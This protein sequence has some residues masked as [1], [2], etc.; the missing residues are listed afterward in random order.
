MGFQRFTGKNTPLKPTVSSR[1]SVTYGVAKELARI[2]KPLTG[3]TIHHVNNSMEFADDIKKI[4]LEEG[5]CIILYDVSALFTSIPVKSA[6]EVTKKKLEQDAE[7]HQRTSMSIHKIL[8]LLEFC[9]CNTYFLFQGQFYEQT[10]GA[11]VG[12]PVNPVVANLYMEF[13]EDKSSNISSETSQ[14]VKKICR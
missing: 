13:F 8:E 12:S 2:V 9:L 11:A 7:L 14:M 1:G 10:Q 5:E 4:K 3:N 6:I